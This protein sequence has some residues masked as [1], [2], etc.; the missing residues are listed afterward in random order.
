MLTAAAG[1]SGAQTPETPVGREL[2]GPR[3]GLICVWAIYATM[4]E[5]SRRC[6]APRNAAFEAEL[7]RSVSQMEEYA[8]R[9]SQAGANVMASYRARQIEHDAGICHPDA[10]AMYTHMARTPPEAMRSETARLLASS[11]P[12]EWGTCL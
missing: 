7:A 9:Q 11:P 1:V 12:V 10:L 5:V 4:L 6:E 3:T 8:E 2:A